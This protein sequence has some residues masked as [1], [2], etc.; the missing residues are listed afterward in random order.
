VLQKLQEGPMAEDKKSKKGMF[1]KIEN[2]D[3]ALKTIKETS[4]AFLVVAGIQ[5]ALGVF[6]APSVLVDA[7]LYAILG[8]I[9]MK[10]KA[11]TAAVLLLLLAGLAAVVTVMN[12]LGIMAEGGTNIILALIVL[13][14]AVRAV[15]ATFKLHGKFAKE[16]T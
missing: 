3:D 7:A 14:A 16:N 12:K 13:W 8:L 9:L 1:A 11:R 6:I 5:G 4:I 10:W 2:R 15:E